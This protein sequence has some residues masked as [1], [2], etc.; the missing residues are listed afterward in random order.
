MIYI[1]SD[2]DGFET[3]N[4]IKKYLEGQH[5]PYQ[6]VG[7]FELVKNDDYPD[8]ASELCQ[9]IS[10][11]DMGILVC[12]TGIGMSIAANRFKTIRAALCSSIFDAMRAREHNNANVLV[13]GAKVIDTPTR[14]S[15]LKVFFSTPF[16][17]EG[18]HKRRVDKLS[19]L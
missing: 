1:A 10:D 17:T 11:D 18:R 19:L 13:I 3:K 16:S 2:H 8:F 9:K 7:P 14:E 15:I 12:D 6:D 4:V 5:V